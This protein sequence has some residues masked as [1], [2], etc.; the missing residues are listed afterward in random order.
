[1]ADS[2]F[3]HGAMEVRKAHEAVFTHIQK[4]AYAAINS[5]NCEQTAVYSSLD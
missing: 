4:Q 1:M 3:K 2:S 5:P